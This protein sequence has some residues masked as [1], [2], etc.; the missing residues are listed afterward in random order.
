[1][2]QFNVQL[3]NVQTNGP[4][5]YVIHKDTVGLKSSDTLANVN[6]AL[7]GIKTDIAASL[8]G[9]TVLSIKMIVNAG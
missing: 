1:M 7:D 4:Y 3:Y 8:G 9:E 6:V 5:A 2:S